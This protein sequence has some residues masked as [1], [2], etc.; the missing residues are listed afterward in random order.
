MLV[1]L[2][3]WQDFSYL[4]LS[5]LCGTYMLES[6]IEKGATTASKALFGQGNMCETENTKIMIS[7]F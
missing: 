2:K 5:G 3:P 1:E 6:Q 4:F 7:S